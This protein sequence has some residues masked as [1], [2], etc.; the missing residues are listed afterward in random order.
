MLRSEFVSDFVHDVGQSQ[1]PFF[2]LC[3]YQIKPIPLLVNESF[4]H[5]S[6]VLSLS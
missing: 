4:P 5:C 6:T 2:L 1:D 3:G